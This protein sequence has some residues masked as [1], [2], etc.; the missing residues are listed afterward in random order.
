MKKWMQK[1][2]AEELS[3]LSFETAKKFIDL[4]Q[5]KKGEHKDAKDSK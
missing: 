3:E 1:N 5:T 4:Y 2:N